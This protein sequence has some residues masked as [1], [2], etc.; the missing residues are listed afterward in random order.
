MRAASLITVIV[1]VA[2]G[3]ALAEQAVTTE[4]PVYFLTPASDGWLESAE[5]QD[6]LPL[7]AHFVSEDQATWCGIASAVM[8]LNALGITRPTAP[9]WYP[10]DYWDQE[11]IFTKE[12]LEKVEPVS[13]VNAE[14]ITLEQLETLLN[15]SGARA[16]KRFASDM[17]VDSFRRTARQAIADPGAI[18]LVNF[19]RAELRQDGGGHISPVAAYDEASD[20]F[21]ILDVARYKY[22]PAWA[23]AERLYAAM[24][25]PDSSSGTTRGYVIARK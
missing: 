11:N 13:R 10:Y 15:L 2:A 16:E 7:M 4:A 18:L 14:G 22:L 23:T 5:Q 8:A 24:N 19:D 1:L 12:V 25:T 20:R 21:L 3:P 17:D 9:Q 6:L